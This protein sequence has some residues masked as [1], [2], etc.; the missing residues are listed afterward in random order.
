M[1]F[2]GMMNRF[3]FLRGSI[4]DPFRYSEERKL[5]AKLLADY[6]ADIAFALSN[7]SAEAAEKIAQLMDLPEHIRGYGHVRERHAD[8]VSKSRD[9]LRTAILT[10]E[11]KAA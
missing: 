3:R 4:L 10:R 2:F 1:F 7:N 6:E 5:D 9:E 8:T 11:V